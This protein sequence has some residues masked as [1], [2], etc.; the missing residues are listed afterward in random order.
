MVGRELGRRLAVAAVGIPLTLVLIYLGG[1]VLAVVMGAVAALMARE[2]YRIGRARDVEAFTW[3][4]V[5]AS[6]AFV[7]L[8]GAHPSFS[9]AAPWAMGLLMATLLLSFAAAVWLRGSERRPMAAVGTTVA[10]TLYGGGALSF[11]VFLRHLP[12][13]GGAGG[14]A[15]PLRGTVLL[16]F[17]LAV[18][19]VGDSAAYL[20]GK[21]YG[22]RKLIPSVSPGKTVE[23]G[24]ASLVA[25]IL[26]GGGLGWSLLRLHPDPLLSALLGGGVGLALA[27][28]AQVG[29]L[30]E[31]VVKREAGVKDS[32]SLLPGHGGV[33]DR[34]DALVFTLPLTYALVS[35]IGFL[36]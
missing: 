3:I 33:M 34:F 5:P 27:V 24:V 32:G 26:T 4:G 16:A 10:G 20:L 7:L 18:T 14:A 9:Q 28:G 17:P 30:A 6:G 19:W 2:F 1:W 8:G 22:R 13:A 12:D 25:S 29:D 35:L 36:S 15:L 11:T 21:R 31:S 23:G